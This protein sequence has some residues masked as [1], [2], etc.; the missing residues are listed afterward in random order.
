MG[1]SPAA[2]GWSDHKSKSC[3]KFTCANLYVDEGEDPVPLNCW[4]PTRACG[5]DCHGSMRDRQRWMSRFCWV[6]VIVGFH[7]LT[8]LQ[9][10]Y[11]HRKVPQRKLRQVVDTQETVDGIPGVWSSWGPW[12]S[13]SSS[14]GIGIA[15]QSRRCIPQEPEGQRW[16]LQPRGPYSQPRPPQG[17]SQWDPYSGRAVSALRPTYSLHVNSDPP[18]LPH[19]QSSP[20]RAQQEPASHHQGEASSQHS[21]PLYGDQFPLNQPE[22]RVYGH[23]R[24]ANGESAP[25]QTYGQLSNRGSVPLYRQGQ[26]SNHDRQRLP[27]NRDS[28]PYGAPSLINRESSPLYT[29]E[30]SQ[31]RQRSVANWRAS[32]GNRRSLM[33]QELRPFNR[34]HTRGAIRPGQYGYGKVPSNFR[35]QG[36]M[37]HLL[38]ATPRDRQRHQSSTRQS[39]LSEDGPRSKSGARQ[40]QRAARERNRARRGSETEDRVESSNWQSQ[41]HV[42]ER[43]GSLASWERGR[44]L[45]AEGLPDGAYQISFA[46]PPNLVKGVKL[47]ASSQPEELVPEA[48]PG[49]AHRPVGLEALSTHNSLQQRPHKQALQDL[50]FTSQELDGPFFVYEAPDTTESIA[51]VLLEMLNASGYRE[52]P[53]KQAKDEPNPQV[54]RKRQLPQPGP[55]SEAQRGA[56]EETSG[57]KGRRRGPAD[58]GVPALTPQGEKGTEVGSVTPADSA[59]TKP[60]HLNQSEAPRLDSRGRWQWT[61]KAQRQKEHRKNLQSP[62]KSFSRPRRQDYSVVTD[63]RTGSHQQDWNPYHWPSAACPGVEKQYKTCSLSACPSGETDPRKAQC[64]GFNHL[65]FMGRYYEWEPF[66]E[67]QKDQQCELNCR[68]SGYRFY[69]RHADRVLDGTPCQANSSDVCVGGHC[70]TA[71]CDGMLGSAAR[72]DKC[73]VCGGDGSSCELVFGMFEDSH[74]NVGYHKIIEIPTGATKINVTEMARSRNYLALRSRS[75]RSIINGNWAIDRAGKYEAAGTMFMYKRPTETSGESFYAE[76]PTTESL[77]V[78][79]IFQQENPGIHYEFVLPVEKPAHLPQSS[80]HPTQSYGSQT[81]GYQRPASALA[82]GPV[83][84]HQGSTGT[85]QGS[86]GTRQGS[87]GTRQGSTGTRQGSTATHQGS[88]VTPRARGGQRDRRLQVYHTDT[89]EDPAQ[90]VHRWISQ[91]STECSA[92]CGKGFQYP[93][94]R[95]VSQNTQ[96]LVPDSQCDSASKPASVA[97]ACNTQPCPAFW[98]VGAWSQCSKTCGRGTHH[99]QV[100]CRQA[101]ANRTVAVHPHR[102]GHL[103]KPNATQP[104]QARACTHWQIQTDWESCSVPCGVGQRKRSIRC[105]SNQG[106]VVGEGECSAKQKPTDSETC[107]MG[108]C[109]RSWFYTDWSSQCSVECGVGV[110]KRSVLC[111]TNYA[112]DPSPESCEGARPPDTRACS[113]PH[114]QRQVQWYTS[115]WSQCPVPCGNGT[116]NRDLICVVKLGNNFTVTARSDCAHLDKPSSVQS[117]SAG[118]CGTRWF[119]TGWSECSKSCMGGVQVREVR[120]LDNA[121]FPS[122]LCDV[123]GK[124]DDQR[125]CHTHPCIPELDENCK[126]KYYNCPVVV[127]AR[128]CVYSYYKMVCCASCTHAERRASDPRRQDLS[129]RRGGA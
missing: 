26:P 52:E 7:L 107:D 23:R 89:Q 118:P 127:Q 63:P 22:S 4:E 121:G 81:A 66:T 101:Y 42:R 110:Q 12:S 95:C 45:A 21:L 83:V 104:C 62:L 105:V 112:N 17:E 91:S 72:P 109:V 90:P 92:S 59:S 119:T 40:A 41:H 65:Q 117:C 128:L 116:Q 43:K 114:C 122:S 124:P 8:I 85:R 37:A 13:C 61:P 60:G 99:R 126:D 30:G 15:Q 58:R 16:T 68:P 3:V 94:F 111:L 123:A 20:L 44:H 84:T 73:G 125:I 78:Y 51:G 55:D 46:K 93:I 18:T 82:S 33:R 102:C 108:P 70:L 88:L 6:S 64:A 27:A 28:P 19:G 11:T 9:F 53:Q 34:S 56:P 29:P 96:E 48:R 31:P 36:A 103:E 87:T 35:L 120:C 5:T 129:G 1:V 38:Q 76:G 25:Y 2:G 50:N 100:L 57:R 80:H 14:C 47:G 106:T 39:R 77:D 115:P 98:S 97:E 49:V 24:P 67:V 75:G 71:G 86:T 32:T 113:R 79:M 54:R 74:V 69:V 10:S